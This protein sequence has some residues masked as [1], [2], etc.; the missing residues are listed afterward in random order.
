MLRAVSSL[1]GLHQLFHSFW[2]NGGNRLPVMIKTGMVNC[3]GDIGLIG[4]DSIASRLLVSCCMH[5]N[6]RNGR[7]ERQVG[8]LAKAGFLSTA[9]SSV[10]PVYS[11]HQ[12]GVLIQMLVYHGL[13][14][15]CGEK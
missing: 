4:K 6:R 7:K 12:K 14:I 10:G 8:F 2:T 11:L 13:L 15:C 9:L 5:W 3:D 1:I